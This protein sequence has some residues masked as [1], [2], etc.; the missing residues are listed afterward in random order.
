[1]RVALLVAGFHVGVGRAAGRKEETTIAANAPELIAE[2]LSQRWLERAC[3]SV[4]AEPLWEPTYRQAPLT[5]A[6]E[7]RLRR[8]PQFQQPAAEPQSVG[9][10]SVSRCLRTGCCQKAT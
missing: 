1:M 5:A 7:E 9:V 6:T 3:R 10:G 8:H 4:S 2:P